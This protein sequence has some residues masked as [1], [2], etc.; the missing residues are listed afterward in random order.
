MAVLSV[1]TKQWSRAEY[2][3]AIA[4]GCFEPNDS[5]EL[6]RGEIVVMT[7]QQSRHATTI[8]LVDAALRTMFD[9][10]CYIRVQMPLALDEHSEPEPDLVVVRGQPRDYVE[11]HP[12][13][14][15]L[16]VEVA[17]T[18]LA[19]DRGPKRDAYAQGGISEYWILNLVDLRL[20]VYR[21]PIN[22]GTP[23]ASY[24]DILSLD[25]TENITPLYASDSSSAIHISELL[26]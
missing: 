14:A 12:T 8:S 22:I 15:L 11:N 24:R 25:S 1:K 9:A 17:D 13:G 4:A 23:N 21:N 3:R 26:P 10:S 6:L 18:S 5:V 16:V 2:E 20:E 7:P 19:Y